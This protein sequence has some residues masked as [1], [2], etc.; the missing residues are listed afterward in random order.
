MRRF[1]EPLSARVTRVLFL[2]LIRSS[3]VVGSSCILFILILDNIIAIA[4]FIKFLFLSLD[5]SLP[6]PL[7]TDDRCCRCLLCN[8]VSSRQ[9]FNLLPF[10]V[11]F[12]LLYSN[13]FVI[14]LDCN[15]MAKVLTLNNILQ[16][17]L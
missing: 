7:D 11:A 12:F 14:H 1:W 6:F 5:Q 15:K 10:V 16:Y 8:K 17:T 4:E 2:F 13:R 3:F 9:N